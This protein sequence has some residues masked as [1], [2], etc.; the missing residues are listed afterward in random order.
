MPYGAK[1]AFYSNDFDAVHPLDC[2]P[3]VGRF[4][5]AL[6]DASLRPKPPSLRRSRDGAF[7]YGFTHT[8]GLDVFCIGPL[9]RL[10]G[11]TIDEV[12]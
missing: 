5:P 6:R 10:S 3:E 12:L 1:L 4:W 8:D 7:G 9:S 11:I 2:I